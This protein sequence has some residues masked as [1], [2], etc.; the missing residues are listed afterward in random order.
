MTD[1]PTDVIVIGAGIVGAACAHEFALRGLRVVVVDDGG[2][3]RRP[4][5][6]AT[7]SR[8]T[9]TRPSSRSRIIRSGCGARCATRCRK[10]A[11]IATAARCGS[12]PMRTRWTSRARSRRRSARAAS[13]A[14]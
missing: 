11:R 14:S 5:A 9:T 13:R 4:R 8:W 3:A 1:S 10:A 2:G 12:R 7:W 6:W